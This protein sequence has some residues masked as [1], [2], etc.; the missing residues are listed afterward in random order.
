MKSKFLKTSFL[1]S[2]MAFFA[3]TVNAQIEGY[4]K[5]DLNLGAQQL[6]VCFNIQSKDGKFVS[7][8]DVPAQGAF[9]V[10]VDETSFAI[11]TLKIEITAINASYCGVY[12]NDTLKG[13]FTQMGIALPLNLARS[14]KEARDLTPHQY[15][16]L[17]EGLS[18]EQPRAIRQLPKKESRDF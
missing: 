15:R 10:A 3:T 2:M 13:T 16:W 18:V 14:E 1:M 11:D 5:G 6:G 9:D 17:M 8:M 12:V 4:W 7:T